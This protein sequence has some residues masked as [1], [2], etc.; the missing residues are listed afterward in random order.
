MFKG[1]YTKVIGQSPIPIIKLQTK[2]LYNSDVIIEKDSILDTG[3]DCTLIPFAIISKLQP[4][5]LIRG[6]HN[7]IIYGVGKNKIVAVPYRIL[8][9]FDQLNFF[10]IKVYACPDD[11]TDGLIIL[12]RNFLNRY[13]ITFDGQARLFYIK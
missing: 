6:R 9:S 12:G 1:A 10:K 4:K 5:A 2:A 11:Y 13:C 8:I 7:Q 3:A